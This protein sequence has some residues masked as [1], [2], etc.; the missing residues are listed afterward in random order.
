MRKSGGMRP[1]SELAA[2]C[3]DELPVKLEIVEDDLEEEHGPLNKRSKVCSFSYFRLDDLFK[4]IREFDRK[5]LFLIRLI[6]FYNEE[7]ALSDVDG[8]KYRTDGLMI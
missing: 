8:E 2:K 6:H 1:E 7:M 5:G 4:L 3:R